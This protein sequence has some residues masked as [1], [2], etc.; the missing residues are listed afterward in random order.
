MIQNK[1][2]R[3]NNSR[4]F[5]A[6]T[7]HNSRSQYHILVNTYDTHSSCAVSLPCSMKPNFI[8][9][10]LTPK[11]DIISWA[12]TNQSSWV[13]LIA[14][15][16]YL[17]KKKFQYRIK[18]P[19]SKLTWLMTISFTKMSSFNNSYET[20]GKASF[21]ENISSNPMRILGKSISSQNTL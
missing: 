18:C 15:H 6:T 13:Y 20:K 5:R 12:L 1:T 8:T 14:T 10:I 17:M 19:L 7:F 11:I 3:R 9:Y 2:N 4:T 21:S 16:W